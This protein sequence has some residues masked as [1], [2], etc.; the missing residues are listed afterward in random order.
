MDVLDVGPEPCVEFV[1]RRGERAEELRR[2]GPVENDD[3]EEAGDKGPK[4]VN[5]RLI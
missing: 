1:I 2:A 5:V 4:A 3:E